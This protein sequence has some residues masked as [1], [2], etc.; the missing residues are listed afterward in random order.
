MVVLLTVYYSGDKIKNNEM[1]GHVAS[2]GDRRGLYKVLVGRAD[3]KTPLGR[4][5]CRWEDNVKMDL[6]EVGWAIMGCISLVQDRDRWRALV[7]VV[8][9]HRLL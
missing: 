2:L 1:E 5:K 4:P 7:N 8:M 9:N 6:R 3:R